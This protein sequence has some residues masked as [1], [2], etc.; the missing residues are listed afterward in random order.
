ML[1]CDLD[2]LGAGHYEGRVVGHPANPILYVHTSTPAEKLVGL[3]I[4]YEDDGQTLRRPIGYGIM[5][6]CDGHWSGVLTEGKA[7]W[8]LS[9]LTG[10]GRVMLTERVLDAQ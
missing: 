1:V 10:S 8:N 5:R 2:H 6:Q 9:A 7:T 4:E 3:W